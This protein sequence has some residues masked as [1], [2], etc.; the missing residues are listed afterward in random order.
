MLGRLFLG[1]NWCGNQIARTTKSPSGSSS[2][3]RGAGAGG[4][5]LTRQEAARKWGTGT[6]FLGPPG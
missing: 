2:A 3:L 5:V 1:R 6:L 4:F